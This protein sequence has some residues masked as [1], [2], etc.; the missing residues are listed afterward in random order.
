MK[1]V[2]IAA[3][4]LALP[5]AALAQQATGHDQPHR[6][7]HR[8][9]QRCRRRPGVQ[10]D[11]QPRR[12][13]GRRWAAS[14]G[15]YRRLAGR[16][17]QL[18]PGL[19]QRDAQ[20]EAFGR[21]ACRRERRRRRATPTISTTPRKWRSCRPRERRPQITYTTASSLPAPTN[22]QLTAPLANAADNVTIRVHSFGTDGRGAARRRLLYERDTASRS[23]PHDREGEGHAHHLENDAGRRC[24]ERGRDFLRSGDNRAADRDRPQRRRQA[25]RAAR[26]PSRTPTPADC[27]SRSVSN[28][29]PSRTTGCGSRVPPAIS[30]SFLPRR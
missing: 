10:R 14:C 27:R 24:G 8:P 5:Q 30:R 22:V 26:S 25:A 20:G 19:H 11:D 13:C 3:A 6:H 7:R 4:L 15:P 1:Y 21:R 17:P 2:A 23:R 18:Q 16:D 9:L 29:S 28:R 12:A